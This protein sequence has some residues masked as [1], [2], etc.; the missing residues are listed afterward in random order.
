[1]SCRV[2]I[3]FLFLITLMCCNAYAADK[4]AQSD[5]TQAASGGVASESGSSAKA[6]SGSIAETSQ[7]AVGGVIDW[8]KG[9][10]DM[11][12]Q[13]YRGAADVGKK[14]GSD[15]AEVGKETGKKAKETF[16]K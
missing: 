5:A 1:M 6:A 9:V 4:G 10:A 15:A 14:V 3:L 11:A 16:S 12:R 8:A 7:T 13:A 2:R